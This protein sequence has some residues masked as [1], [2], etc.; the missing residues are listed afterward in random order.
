MPPSRP[1]KYRQD[2][3][4]LNRL[5]RFYAGTGKQMLS[6]GSGGQNAAIPVASQPPKPQPQAPK[7]PV[8]QGP[9]PRPQ[10]QYI[11]PEFLRPQPRPQQQS[12]NQRSQQ[13]QTIVI[14]PPPQP[15]YNPLN[16][17][18]P[19]RP[20]GPPQQPAY[21]PL[22]SAPPVRPSGPP[23]QPA[24]NPLA[25]VN[26][27]VQPS[28]VQSQYR[29]PIGPQVQPQNPYLPMEST[30]NRVPTLEELGFKPQGLGNVGVGARPNTGPAQVGQSGVVGGGVVPSNT[31]LPTK[32]GPPPQPP[33]AQQPISNP[34]RTMPPTTQSPAGKP[35]GPQP[36]PQADYIAPAF[37]WKGTQYR[38]QQVGLAFDR[39]NTGA[40]PIGQSGVIN[41]NQ[42]GGV[43]Q[44]ASPYGPVQG[45][46][47]KPA[48]GYLPSADQL[49]LVP[50]GNF[51]QGIRRPV[52]QAVANS[53]AIQDYLRRREENQQWYE[54][55]DPTW[56][57]QGYRAVAGA[58]SNIGNALT[59]GG[60]L[61]AELPIGKI[62]NQLSLAMG[63]GGNESVEQLTAA[64]ITGAFGAGLNKILN[65]FNPNKVEWNGWMPVGQWMGVVDKYLNDSIAVHTMYNE[66]SPAEKQKAMP[67]LNLLGSSGPDMADKA[68]YEILNR[69][70]LVS[71]YLDEAERMKAGNDQLGAARAYNKAMEIKNRSTTDTI[72]EYTRAW[73][74][75]VQGVVFDPTMVFGPIAKLAE[76]KGIALTP[77]AA[78]RIRYADWLE[79]LTPE[80][81]G[82]ELQKALQEGA[83]LVKRVEA[84]G[85]LYGAWQ[86][87]NPFAKT[88]EA[89]VDKAATQA[90][91]IFGQV[92]AHAETGAEAKQLLQA[93]FDG[94]INQ[95]VQL[96]ERMVQ[97]APVVTAAPESVDTIAKLKTIAQKILESPVLQDAEKPLNR[98]AALGE[99]SDT[100]Y[101]GLRE[102]MGLG[103]L[104][105][106]PIG[107]VSARTAATAIGTYVV[108]YLDKAGKV[109]KTS[110][111][112]LPYDAQ[113]LIKN[114]NQAGQTTA[115]SGYKTLVNTQRAIMSSIY[116]NLRP[117]HWVR[118]AASA[119]L[120]NTL[121][122]NMSYAPIR[123]I[124]NEMA[125][126]GGGAVPAEIRAAI[127]E[128]AKPLE[129]AIKES[130]WSFGGRWTKGNPL[131]TVDAMAGKVWQSVDSPLGENAMRVRSFYAGFQ[132]F[133]K[134]N[135]KRAAQTFY[136]ELVQ[137]GME[138]GMAKQFADH[139]YEVGVLGRNEMATALR[140]SINAAT[141]PFT[142]RSLG[143]DVDVL[144]PE[145]VRDVVDVVNKARTGVIDQATLLKELDDIGVSAS[146]DAVKVLLETPLQPGRKLFTEQHAAQ[147]AMDGIQILSEAATKAGLP[148]TAATDVVQEAVQAQ[149]TALKAIREEMQAAPTKEMLN[150]G[151]EYWWKLDQEMRRVRS[152]ADTLNR[153]AKDFEKSGAA[154][155]EITAKWQETFGA[156]SNLWREFIEFTNK[157]ADAA[158]VAGTSGQKV[159]VDL[160]EVMQRYLAFDLSQNQK[161]R[162]SGKDLLTKA[163]RDAN[164]GKVIDAGREYS[165][166]AL[167]E[168]LFVFRRYPSQTAFDIVVSANQDTL[169]EGGRVVA[170][171]RNEMDRMLA[172][173]VSVT[174]F[175]KYSHEAWSAFFDA[176]H[177]RFNTAK[178]EVVLADLSE[179]AGV[180]L[181][182]EDGFGT[183]YRLIQPRPDGNF[184]VKN[185]DTN[186][187]LV[188]PPLR[189]GPT[190]MSNA[191]YAVPD[192]VAKSYTELIDGADSTVAKVIDEVKKEAASVAPAVKR[193]MPN[194]QT[195]T[196]PVVSSDPTVSNTLLRKP[197]IIFAGAN[198][199][200]QFATELDKLFYVASGHGVQRRSTITQL[201]ELGY[202]YDEIMDFGA[203]VRSKVS[204]TVRS[205]GLGQYANY[206]DVALIPQVVSD[207]RGGAAILPGSDNAIAGAVEGIAPSMVELEA[208]AQALGL[209]GGAFKQ[210]I[211]KGFT[212]LGLPA[213]AVMA[214]ANGTERALI[215]RL[216]D[217]RMEGRNRA[218]A[219]MSPVRELINRY[220]QAVQEA[221]AAQQMNREGMK[222]AI[223]SMRSEWSRVAVGEWD[224]PD[225]EKL[226]VRFN[227]Y[228]KGGRFNLN[229]TGVDK[230]FEDLYGSVIA[231]R[232]IDNL[233]DVEMF[234]NGYASL[235]ADLKNPIKQAVNVSA[236]NV[237]SL[238]EITA[239]AEPLLRL[240]GFGDEDIAKF[241]TE[242]APGDLLDYLKSLV[243][244]GPSIEDVSV[245]D[246]IRSWRA[247]N[248]TGAINPHITDS[249][250]QDA[251]GMKADGAADLAKALTETNKAVAESGGTIAP[252]VAGEAAQRNEAILHAI[253]AIKNNLDGVLT[254]GE[255]QLSEAQRLRAID[256]MN[257]LLQGFDNVV[258]GATK[259]G[260]EAMNFS[261][262]NFGDRRNIDA[263]L[264]LLAPFHYYWSRG[265]INWTKRIASNPALA[266]AV[267]NIYR[268]VDATQQQLSDERAT[269][270][271]DTLPNPLYP[272]L[273][274]VAPKVADN[275]RYVSN[276]LAWLM[277][278]NLNEFVD[279]DNANSQFEKWLLTTQQ[280]LPGL[281]PGSQYAIDSALD[282]FSPL[283]NGKKRTDKY[284]LADY[285]PPA[286]MAGYARQ[287]A[288][289]QMPPGQVGDE[290]DYGRV[291]REV[292]L[293]PGYTAAEKKMAQDILYQ[294]QNGLP[295]LPEQQM[296]PR[297]QE[298]VTI[299]SKQAGV[300]RLI[301]MLTGWI[302]G[303]NVYPYSDAEEQVR[304][305][306]AERRTLGYDVNPYGSKAAIK[307]FDNAMGPNGQST[308]DTLSPWYQY[309]ALYPST[310]AAKPG[311]RPGVSAATD[312]KFD[313][314]KVIGDAMNAAIA[315]GVDDYLT[316]NPQATKGEMN[317]AKVAAA[318][319]Y[320]QS[321]LGADAVQAWVSAHPEASLG[322]VMK[323]AKDS[324]LQGK[325]PSALDA[326]ASSDVDKR[327]PDEK[328]R[329]ANQELLRKVADWP[330][331]P[332]Y[333]GSGASRAQ[334]D[335]YNAALAKWED[336][337]RS[338][339]ASQWTGMGDS[340]KAFDAYSTRYQT[341]KE[342]SR[343]AEIEQ[344][345]ANNAAA[346]AGRRKRVADAWGED[347]AK[348]WEQYYDL[349][350][351]EARQ[352]FKEQH[353]EL[354]AMNILAYN[355]EEYA[356]AS[357]LFGEDA[358]A[359]WVAQP[360]YA[361]TEEAKAA[362]R[363]YQDK[364]PQVRLL[365]AWLYGRPADNLEGA[366]DG[367]IGFQ[368][369]FGA[370]YEEAKKLFGDGIWDLFKSYSSGWSKAQ[371]RE[372]FDQ[373]PEY[374]D[375]LTW[376][377]GDDGKGGG[378]GGGRSRGGG[379]G[380]G[381]YSY[382]YK[383]P[384]EYDRDV[385]IYPQEMSNSLGVSSP[386]TANTQWVNSGAILGAGRD[387]RPERP[388]EF[389]ARWVK[390]V[391]PH[392]QNQDFRARW[393]QDIS[394]ERIRAWRPPQKRYLL[395]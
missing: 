311:D 358:W 196:I 372:F 29:Q 363:A 360:A 80:I 132:K 28:P 385:R 141:P 347:G 278:Y 223:D 9:Q 216:L 4:E 292:A 256:A 232:R 27:P 305:L 254:V 379:G 289:G 67:A 302:T 288:T 316:R 210:Y 82:Q 173:D 160:V 236:R 200:V 83:K 121:D 51:G 76:A 389:R 325:Y 310:E 237:T 54:Q 275:F 31:Q 283:G 115:M 266:H 306:A 394:P 248:P 127:T 70:R 2:E 136:E 96:G 125:A 145:A 108:E 390:S 335:A 68:M 225:I 84:G 208:K 186:E 388:Q 23:A 61:M 117:A 128:S 282:M 154:A 146:E 90:D 265:T 233:N 58:L 342:R 195:A 10:Q 255:K 230:L 219:A 59:Y 242:Y 40:A 153:A 217:L 139:A 384:V 251:F 356:A 366:D 260:R 359:L 272:L 375:F 87:F 387:L 137:V 120:A 74:E 88:A 24:Y 330:G 106:V 326:F 104:P 55:A 229:G 7:P 182:Y 222:A 391:T 20:S 221:R 65:P 284:Q 368:Y 386:R 228:R 57:D 238:E 264:G 170:A 324:Y 323:W 382:H 209:K 263:V 165:D 167:R 381:G 50:A 353:P 178:V 349:P 103:K 144:P 367:E 378:G 99:L 258:F 307:Q 131:A 26:R 149:A 62:A 380:G 158:R 294:M 122:G 64:D 92:L 198:G 164:L 181:V 95:G 11:P 49:A 85:S 138:P 253:A 105:D 299:A 157:S 15:T 315:K 373:H 97:L 214:Q 274:Q 234:L 313:E 318:L 245:M 48:N 320:A 34:W 150:A 212:E 250:L 300:N 273:Q 206:Q 393:L 47:P 296:T 317:D 163:L 143:I 241:G 41:G 199:E 286:R 25:S 395:K 169:A 204:E 12:V 77:A 75:I 21:N 19:V 113:Q 148:E 135:L 14:G 239:A 8:V 102:V 392:L 328:L 280:F 327:S 36:K 337:R 201:A 71:S 351:G 346:W 341:D 352:K 279:P 348:L 175:Y 191:A 111:E 188:A 30:D 257:R 5:R 267:M 3:E 227:P 147:E 354:K 261:M 207:V 116:L 56:K 211:E 1:Q 331:R 177:A 312:M 252:T 179:K 176:S 46:R 357:K 129:E 297:A 184:L 235:K 301:P 290:Y 287:M 361:D 156:T 231:G 202:T 155:A 119:W 161:V 63:S 69:D 162:A 22:H 343:V 321:L 159:G 98:W 109:L 374:S 340:S 285:F 334:W 355:P 218:Q 309:K 295:P 226:M 350:K 142:L 383:M 52:N 370:D 249:V 45:P 38:P 114:F 180:S 329:D 197:K 362:R 86:K 308:I 53:P 271:T 205:G 185:L 17:A 364:Y 91:S 107:T 123:K 133:F 276:P 332:A 183:K 89:V 336:E 377:Y 371:K 151:I 35:F 304:K 293:V 16:S 240:V 213:P 166:Q 18:P 187:Y 100:V 130:I 110:A 277:P 44:G 333:P 43:R 73:G 268:G 72:N 269:R 134:P 193:I 365:S 369:N 32:M 314:Q 339:L 94:T 66:M 140:E 247:E 298:L 215:G 13:P 338:Y 79:N 262:L 78:Q 118:N 243:V 37:A 246:A 224:V 112:M 194:P 101:A 33:Q 93:I 171:V 172:K 303:V 60:K 190:V 152:M 319:A 81:A 344:E 259:V 39:P 281:M 291:G 124:V 174:D 189:S 244:E 126:I 42:A 220:S 168:L 270:L 192:Q 376:W 345:R 322:E 6:Q 203:K